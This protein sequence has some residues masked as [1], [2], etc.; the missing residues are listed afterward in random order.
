[1]KNKKAISTKLEIL[2]IVLI[3]LFL[4]FDALIIFYLN[5]NYIAKKDLDKINQITGNVIKTT[6][7]TNTNTESNTNI[8]TNTNT[9]TNIQVTNNESSSK[10]SSSFSLITSR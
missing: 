7:T 10:Q 8:D 5:S 3:I 4:L 6:D 1:M 9:N 2:I